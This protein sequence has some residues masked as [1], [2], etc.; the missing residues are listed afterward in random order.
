[1]KKK[2]EN[3]GRRTQSYDNVFG[4]GELKHDFNGYNSQDF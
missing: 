4:Q 3:T 1:M 2:N